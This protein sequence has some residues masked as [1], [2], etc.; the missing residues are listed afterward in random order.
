MKALSRRVSKLE[1]LRTP[2]QTESGPTLAEVVGE[3]RRRRLELAGIPFDVR[4]PSGGRTLTEVI[5]N[6]RQ[7][8]REE[9]RAARAA[10][11]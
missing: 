11:E 5:R 1:R 4:P 9:Q 7:R 3:R 8:I 2:I 10:Q 6:C